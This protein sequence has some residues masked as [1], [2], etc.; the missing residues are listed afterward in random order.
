[1]RFWN[2]DRRKRELN[3]EL[4]THLRFAIE[5]RVARGESP[6]EARAAALREIGNLPLVADTTRRQWGWE[7]LERFAQ[8]LRYAARQLIKNWGITATAVTALALGIGLSVTLFSVFYNGVLNPFPYRAADR[9][10]VIGV[11]DLQ[12]SDGSRSAFHLNEIA[13]FREQNHTFED[14]VAYGGARLTYRHDGI[15][16]PVFACRMS[17]NATTFWGV[18]PL[19]GRSMSQMDVKSGASPVVVLGYQFWKKTSGGDPKVIGTTMLLDGAARTVVGVMPPRFA[20]YGADIYIPLDWRHPDPFV[21]ADSRWFDLEFYFATGIRKPGVS[22]EAAAADMQSIAQHTMNLHREDFPPN[23]QMTTRRMNDVIVAHF[24]KTLYLLIGMVALLLLISSTNVASLL[25]AQ[26]TA[27]AR[28]TALRAAL[29]ASRGTLI[30]Q[31]L[32]ESLLLGLTGCVAGCGLAWLGFRFVELTPALSLP[33]EAAI[34]LNLPVLG[35]A[36]GLSLLTTL[37]F[38]LLPALVAAKKAPWQ[39]LQSA[40]VN[41]GEARGG[42]RTR[43]GLVVFQVAMS[44]LLL[45][46]AGLMMRSFLAITST[47]TG[48][49][50]PQ[51]ILV[52][53]IILPP[54]SYL[55]IAGQNLFVGQTMERV[56]R[57]PGV[58]H[59]AV[60]IGFPVLGTAVSDDIALTGKPHDTK[61]TTD[62]DLVSEDYFSA[63]GIG[64]VQGRLMTASEAAGAAPVAVVNQAFVRAYMGGDGALGRVVTFRGQDRGLEMKSVPAFSIVGVVSDARN[65]GLQE[66]VNPEVFVPY[67]VATTPARTLVIRTA[68]DPAALE[69]S[70]RRVLF[71]IDPNVMLTEQAS[72]EETLDKS[73]F[74]NPRYRLETF[75]ICAAIGL[76]LA[77]V[78]L[79]GIMA[80]TVSLQT[81]EFGIRMALGAQPCRIVAL[82]VRRG[83]L[84]VGL[85]ITFGLGGALLIVQSLRTELTGI[86]AFDSVAFALAA[87]ILAA[88]GF[89]ACVIPARRAATVDPLIA[90]RHD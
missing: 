4:E 69:N 38:G 68:T 18:A 78:G 30:G 76:G 70:I 47:D 22:L 3:E 60:S 67:S 80:F 88:T 2:W 45:V 71:T 41:V 14:I 77:L 81:H 26:H 32:L 43:A 27:R 72:V 83:M 53:T 19:L 13:A 58:V 65:N 5:E 21:S 12:D 33:G 79:F 74:L 8:D 86:S 73:V 40:G 82:V 15:S 7:R 63:T 50:H 34:T 17:P 46:V 89:A 25:L 57:I 55:T 61:W 31:F 36:V 51:H 6:E 1:M 64:L 42:G 84:L 85:G 10:T 49:D 75:G 56:K 37:L 48:L 87:A 62:F 24:K 52:S 90:L 39:S 28:D 11:R 16:L 20:L 29:G 35:F 44:M 23:F 59:A 9:L 66:P 54:K